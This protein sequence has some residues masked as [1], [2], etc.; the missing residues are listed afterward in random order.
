M[1]H[2]LKLPD[3]TRERLMDIVLLQ[4]DLL[5]FAASSA[6]VDKDPCASYLDNHPLNE[7]F[8][9]HG[10]AIAGWF[11]APRTSTRHSY[12]VDFARL[13]Q[14]E[15]HDKQVWCVR[16]RKEV[17]EFAEM[18]LD[19][20]KTSIE[21]ADFFDGRL[22]P[23]RKRDGPVQTW[24]D[25]AACFFLYCYE[26]FLGEDAVFPPELFSESVQNGFGRQNLLKAFL[27]ENKGLEICPACDASL[28]YVRS[29]KR[30]ED[31]EEFEKI[32]A[33]LDH[34]LPKSRYPHFA[35]HPY[36]LIAV[37]HT[38][39]STF[40]GETDP[41]VVIVD[42]Q[43]RHQPLYRSIL[44]YGDIELSSCAYL[45][46]EVK[47]L[48]QPITL[49]KL[50][51]RSN[52][53]ELRHV[54]ELLER[55]YGIP[56]RWHDASDTISEAL[57]RR[58]RQFLGNNSTMATALPTGFDV[59][60]EVNNLLEQLLFYLSD[61]SEDFRKDPLAFAMTW[62]LVALINEHVQPAIEA[63]RD[64]QTNIDCDAPNYDP[65]LLEEFV[66]WFGQDLE[67]NDK[68]ALKARRLLK[69]PRHGS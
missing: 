41:L 63:Q 31:G 34:F 10:Q 65:S 55:A 40:K 67:E 68:R 64:R 26:T 48:H 60:H 8:K 46:V 43:T 66:S 16:L 47:Q 17:C 59:P 53:F 69:V 7:H 45:E 56:K 23:N 4:I 24:R 15:R 33:T 22:S 49:G 36:N 25:A 18:H 5:H 28:F 58:I 38:C 29:K 9:G 62:V 54:L 30:S 20:N 35:C 12:L 32:H 3:I 50:L 2:G 51:P 13:G 21:I 19:A 11:W 27:E 39:N 1:I 57:F 6:V 14:E 61:T 42:G 44:P 52:D 37:C